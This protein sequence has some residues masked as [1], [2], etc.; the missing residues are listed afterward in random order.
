MTS[1]NSKAIG[2]KLENI[3]LSEKEDQSMD[4]SVLH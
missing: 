3:I 4:A 1:Y 2:R